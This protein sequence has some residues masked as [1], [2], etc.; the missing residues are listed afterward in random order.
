[1]PRDQLLQHVET[2]GNF[3]RVDYVIDMHPRVYTKNEHG[4]DKRLIDQ[5]ALKV[6]RR[7][8]QNGFKARLVGGGV[9]D[10]LLRKTP[11]D[12]D[13]ATDAT[14]NE[15]RR[16]FNNS[17]VIGKRFKLV[18][19]YFGRGKIVEVATFRASEDTS[20]EEGPA[21]S[22]QTDNTFGTEE[23]DA[24]RR[25]LT[26][27]GLFYDADTETVIDYVEGMTDLKQGIIRIIGDPSTRFVEDPV[28]MLRVI[29]HAVRAGFMVSADTWQSLLEQRELINICAPMRLYEEFKK[30]IGSTYALPI[31]RLLRQGGLLQLL[32]PEITGAS[33]KHGHS[34]SQLLRNLDLYH[35]VHEE[36]PFS[37]FLSGLIICLHEGGLT[38]EDPPSDEELE[39]LLSEKFRNPLSVPRRIKENSLSILRLWFKVVSHLYENDGVPH[40]NKLKFN[41]KESRHA[42]LVLLLHRVL[43]SS[44]LDSTIYK[45]LFEVKKLSR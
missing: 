12:F 18:H 20:E 32:I 45:M 21:K 37:L 23:T 39:T 30:D 33:L 29:R 25:D 40:M 15:I 8:S 44:E 11:K 35:E 24:R 1:V 2:V 6:L 5:D 41:R 36:T 43:P 4:I 16:V 19:V 34:L 31:L 26:V 28:R 7:L 17:R 14:P 10:L 42:D 22:L 9:R 3:E 27:N 13:I 38:G